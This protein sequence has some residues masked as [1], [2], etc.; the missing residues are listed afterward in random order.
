LALVQHSLQ[1]PS[2]SPLSIRCKFSIIYPILLLFIPVTC[3]RQLDLYLISFWSTGSTFSSSN[4][5]SFLCGQKGCTRRFFWKI[6]SWFM[7]AVF[8]LSF[9]LRIQ[10]LLP[11]K[12]MWTASAL[13]T[14]ILQNFWTKAGLKVF[15]K[16]H[17]IRVNSASFVEYF[18]HFIIIIIII[19]IQPLSQF[20]QER[21]PS[22]ATGMTLVCCILG[23]F[24]E[25]VCHCFPTSCSH[26]RVIS[27]PS[28]FK[29][30]Y[31]LKHFLSTTILHHRGDFETSCHLIRYARHLTNP[32]NR[33][34][35]NWM[36]KL[37]IL[38]H[39]LI[40]TLQTFIERK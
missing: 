7:S 16:I 3:R 10:I 18:V 27:Q 31:F 25:V 23:K 35:K 33:F 12:R 15:F 26:S 22:Q 24:L 37:I 8:F 6:S 9:L 14:F 36:F 1:S 34:G 32:N 19:S 29:F 2:K 21:E 5:S 39:L 28:Y 40:Y 38:T 20:G 11:Y 17:S 30:L 4:S 13:E